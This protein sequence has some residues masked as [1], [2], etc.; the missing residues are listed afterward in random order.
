MMIDYQTYEKY[1]DR[2]A[3][4]PEDAEKIAQLL[5]EERMKLSRSRPV[6]RP[7]VSVRKN[8]LV[9]AVSIV[10]V[11]MVPVI[12]ILTNQGWICTLVATIICI[13]LFGV[14]SLKRLL[15]TLILL[16]QKYAPESVRS[17]CLFEPCCSEYMRQSII[18]YGVFKGI[19]N[20][21]RRLK[22]CHLPNGGID[23]P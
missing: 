13:V 7:T 18:K 2:T 6:I 19:K 12:C 17:A 1:G 23:L 10:P 9:S 16:Y 21:I 4:P 15:L 5:A 20:G 22:R 14:F 11:I 3:I 8:V